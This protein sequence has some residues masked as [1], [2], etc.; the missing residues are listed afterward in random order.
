M[1]K[2]NLKIDNYSNSLVTWNSKTKGCYCLSIKR[3][4]SKSGNRFYS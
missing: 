1:R 4:D 3:V 2:V